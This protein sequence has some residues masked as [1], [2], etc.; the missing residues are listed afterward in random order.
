[1][2]NIFNCANLYLRRTDWKDLALIKICLCS[3]GIMLGLIVSKDKKKTCFILA[4]LAFFLTY[5]PVMAKFLKSVCTE[6]TSK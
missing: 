2:K 3:I 4:F 5:I 1:M 6:C